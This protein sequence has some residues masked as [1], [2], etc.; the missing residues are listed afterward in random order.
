M[1]PVMSCPQMP[2]T[3]LKI[4]GAKP[5]EKPF[6]ISDERGLYLEVAPSGGKWWRFKYRFHK[7]EK[8]LSLGVYPD[9]T[10]AA[11]RDRRDDARK[12]LANGIDPSEHRKSANQAKSNNPA[13]S[14][15]AVAREWHVKQSNTWSRDYADK[16]IRRFELHIFPWLGARPIADIKVPELLKTL[17]RIEGR[18]IETAHRAMQTCGQVF[19]Y[20]IAT[21]RAEYDITSGMR[22]A[23][24]P[25]RK[26]HFAS[27]TD[28]VKLGPLLRDMHDYRGTFPVRSALRLAPLVFLRPGELRLAEWSEFDLNNSVWNVPAARMKMKKPHL[29]PLSRQVLAILQELQALTGTGTYVFEG[30]ANNKPISEN[31]INVALQRMGY[32]T[33]DDVTGHGFRATA[34]TIL[35]EVLGFR[36]DVIE[37]QLAHAVRDPNGNAYNRTTFLTERREMMQ[38]WA[39]Y[40]DGLRNEAGEGHEGSGA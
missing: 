21:G 35:D 30:R 3:D 29:V 12:L 13:D 14:F 16:V 11:A 17:H 20:A 34:R 32:S 19:R 33:K 36:P 4:K 22:G 18:A 7:K 2:L 10:L 5:K 1:D 27:I 39:D 31:T 25:W 9:V 26:V 28:P 23:L 24:T 15:E 8:R 38:R 37:H 40:L 6:R